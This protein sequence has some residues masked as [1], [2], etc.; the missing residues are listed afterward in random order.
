MKRSII[1][2]ILF[3]LAGIFYLAAAI[4]GSI[5]LYYI[6]GVILIF[7]GGLYNV[8]ANMEKK[9]IEEEKAKAKAKEKPAKTIKVNNKKAKI[10]KAEVEPIKK[11]KKK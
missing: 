9:D 3:F 11:D 7:L 10:K 5:P 8:R 2:A 4:K 1:C 6:F